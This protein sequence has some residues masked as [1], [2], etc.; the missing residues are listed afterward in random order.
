M[1]I[2]YQIQI[3]R[4]H[5]LRMARV[6]HRAVDCSIKGLEY[7]GPDF[8]RVVFE[9]QTEW[10]RVQ[11]EI[12]EWGRALDAGGALMD[13]ES[14]FACHTLRI[15]GSLR[16]TYAAATEIA[17]N[18]MLM[19]EH[20]RSLRLTDLISMGRFLNA[21][22]SLY[23]LALCKLERSYAVTI[24]NDSYGWRRFDT[25][26]SR[27]RAYLAHEAGAQAHHEL[28]VACSLGQIA[29]Q[30]CEIAETLKS[31]VDGAV[32]P[33]ILCDCVGSVGIQVARANLREST[34]GIGRCEREA[35]LA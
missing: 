15:Y 5:V 18:S 32:R 27:V 2:P 30:A 9:S 24:L 31:C 14:P 25:A 20:E 4:S 22:T 21:L 16:L 7:G 26:L 34:G 1:Q 12:H 35:A 10:R 19:G 28:V 3:L 23:T 13:L 6:S 29:Q 17:R 8:P 11:A 33:E